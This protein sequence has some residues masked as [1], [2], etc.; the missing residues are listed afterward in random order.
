MGMGEIGVMADGGVETGD[1][2]FE[3]SEGLKGVATPEMGVSQIWT[4][5]QDGVEISQGA[6]RLSDRLKQFAAM[7]VE[8]GLGGGGQDRLVE[9]LDRLRCAPPDLGD[10]AQQVERVGMPGIVLQDLTIQRLGTVQVSLL[11]KLECALQPC[12]EAGGRVTG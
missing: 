8:Q 1:R 4:E 7:Q 9:Q 12:N 6:V 11:M 10:Q 3:P 5:S 2:L